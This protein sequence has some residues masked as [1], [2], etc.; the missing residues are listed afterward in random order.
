MRGASFELGRTQQYVRGHDRHADGLAASA[1]RPAN[2]RR[3]AHPQIAHLAREGSP[4][5]AI[6]EWLRGKA[7]ISAPAILASDLGAGLFLVED[8][9]DFVFGQL[10]ADGAHVEPLYALA[11]DGLL[12]IRASQP[13]QALPMADGTPYRVPDYGREA[14]EVELD[15]LLQWYFKLAAGEPASPELAASFF[16][17]WS[18]YLDW[19]DTQPKDLVLRDYHSP[20]LLLCESRSGLRRVGAID[21]QDAGSGPSRLRSR[22][23]SAGCAAGRAG[24]GRTRAVRAL[25]PGRG[26]GRS[27]LRPR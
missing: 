17:A 14:L 7:G 13:P 24:S 5:L 25:L 20:N 10:I 4:F 11:V 8:L 18:P 22:L 15:L 23:A 9:G 3:P 26:Q 2:P 27:Q 1:R 21:F 19:L 16:S 6:S 12:A